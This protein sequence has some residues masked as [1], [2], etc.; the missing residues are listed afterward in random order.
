MRR[1]VDECRDPATNEVNHTL[2][3]E[4]TADELNAYTGDDFE[5]PEQFFEI[6]ATFS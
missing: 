6:A 4:K 1:Y 5:I 3:A 2:L